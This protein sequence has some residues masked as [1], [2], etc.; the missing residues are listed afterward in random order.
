MQSEPGVTA[1]FYWKPYLIA[2]ASKEAGRPIYEDRVYVEIAVAGMAKQIVNRPVQD[3]D[4]VRFHHEWAAFE[5][6]EEAKK[7]GTPLALWPRVAGQPSMIAM[8]EANAIYSVEDVAS[9]PDGRIG[10]LGMGGYK[11]RDEARAFIAGTA[12]AA[13]AQKA[14]ALEAENAALKD[15]LAALET[16]F[17]EMAEAAPARKKP[18]PKPKAAA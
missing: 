16:K 6:G 3:R 7:T 1:K 18:G 14:E 4:K 11:I 12:D 8:L 13:A 2:N 5:R 10:A 9:L 15:R 17:A